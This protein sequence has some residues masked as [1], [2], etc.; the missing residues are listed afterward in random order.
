MEYLKYAGKATSNSHA[1]HLLK[2][3]FREK[4]YEDEE[5]KL[6]GF[7]DRIHTDFDGEVTLGDYKTSNRYGI[8]IKNEYE[9]Q[10]ALYAL[11][12]KRATGLAPDFTSIIFV[13][14]GHEV[15]TRV[16]PSQ[17]D[18]AL[19][20]VKETHKKTTTDKIE[21]YP[22]KEQKLCKWCAFFDICSGEEK[23]KDEKRIEKF[24]EQVKKS[25]TQTPV[26]DKEPK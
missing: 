26:K 5:L 2:P 18:M 4:F 19:T 13:R 24:M 15:R 17:I 22:K 14:F 1:F 6:C 21:D 11:L 12:H 7:V 10:C 20:L 16:T 9:I 25:T 23:F 8:G 3:R